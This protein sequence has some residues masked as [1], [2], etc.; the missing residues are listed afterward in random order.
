MN[1]ILHIDSSIFGQNGQSATLGNQLVQGLNALHEA[2]VVV[3][4]NL[5]VEPIPHFDAQ[6]VAA[7]GEG[8]AELADTL[9][10]ELKQADTVVIGA[11]MYNFAVPTQ[12]KAWFDHITRAGVSFKYTPDGPI[13]LLGKKKVFVITT[14]GGQHVTTD[15]DAVTPWLRTML[16]F[17]GLDQ[18]LEFIQVEGLAQTD[19]KEQARQQAEDRIKEIL[20]T[21]TEGEEA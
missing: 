15:R 10:D 20:T 16:G 2:A 1:K 11:P 19:I 5:G 6:T 7:I 9:I 18:D 8:K 17:I 12:L 21:L 3:H 4:R 14:S 13:G